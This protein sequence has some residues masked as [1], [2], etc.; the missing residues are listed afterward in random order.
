MAKTRFKSRAQLPE[1]TRPWSDLSPPSSPTE[2]LRL[3]LPGTRMTFSFGYLLIGDQQLA[4]LTDKAID[5]GLVDGFGGADNFCMA[6]F[7]DDNGNG[8]V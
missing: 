4:L 1:A 6:H 3:R 8:V 7:F 5:R 2:T